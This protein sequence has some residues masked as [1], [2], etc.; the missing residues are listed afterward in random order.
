MVNAARNTMLSPRQAR[1]IEAPAE[2][3][4]VPPRQQLST[5]TDFY[6]EQLA[7]FYTI[8]ALSRHLCDLRPAGQITQVAG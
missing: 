3:R 1:A 6:G 2:G 7:K 8:L 5:E 4:M